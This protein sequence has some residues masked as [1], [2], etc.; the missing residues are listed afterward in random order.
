MYMEAFGSIGNW[1]D[2]IVKRGIEAAM[3]RK[4]AKE[5]VKSVLPKQEV[6]PNSE[7]GGQM[8]TP[9]AIQPQADLNKELEAS[10]KAQRSLE[11]KLANWRAKAE[12]RQSLVKLQQKEINKMKLKEMTSI[13]GAK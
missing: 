7:G 3:T 11:K 5:D 10:Q 12:Y 2:S 8:A 1:A 4:I 9:Q 6:S 13:G